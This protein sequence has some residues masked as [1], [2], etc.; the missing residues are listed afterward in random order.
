MATNENKRFLRGMKV[1]EAAGTLWLSDVSCHVIGSL[2]LDTF[3]SVFLPK[4]ERLNSSA[5]KSSYYKF[6][7]DKRQSFINNTTE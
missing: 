6:C 5:G 7:T 4:G 3:I 2:I 1:Q